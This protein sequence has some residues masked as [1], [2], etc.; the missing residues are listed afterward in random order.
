VNDKDRPLAVA[1]GRRER[2]H[3]GGHQEESD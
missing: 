1:F 2:V 3:R